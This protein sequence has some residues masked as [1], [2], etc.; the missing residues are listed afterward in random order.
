MVDSELRVFAA[1]R[2]VPWVRALGVGLLVTGYANLLAQSARVPHYI[3]TM[4]PV[5]QGLALVVWC[6]WAK[7]L[8]Q[9][10]KGWAW[11]SPICAALTV[12]LYVAEWRGLAG[13][14]IV[15]VAGV[16]Y[17][18]LFSFFTLGL[19]ALPQ[20]ALLRRARRRG[21]EMPRDNA[22]V[23]VLHFAYTVIGLVALSNLSRA[24][25]GA[26]FLETRYAWATFAELI[27]GALLALIPPVVSITQQRARRGFF[28]RVGQGLEPRYR[29]VV[30]Q[31]NERVLVR[32]ALPVF[33]VAA[34]RTMPAES[35]AIGVVT[36]E[37][38]VNT[39][40]MSVEN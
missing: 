17:W 20:R 3:C 21:G 1:S 13:A 29:I 4:H 15:L 38:F 27:W 5:S 36:S 40:P 2:I 35:E 14:L 25:F 8:Q 34:Y 32:V 19:F 11:L 30:N 18:V 37:G 12:S 6:V 9:P 33:D 16:F 10:L 7:A 22:M 39:H 31:D 23:A 24:G 26:V 28:R